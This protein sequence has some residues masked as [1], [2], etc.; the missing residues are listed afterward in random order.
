MYTNELP[1]LLST[2]KLF[3]WCSTWAFI[4]CDTVREKTIKLCKTYNICKKW[5][6]KGKKTINKE[7]CGE[8]EGM[9]EGRGE[10][11]NFSEMSSFL[12]GFCEGMLNF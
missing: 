11:S 9:T 7:E 10:K 5:Q 12:S 1:T 8:E 3:I 4:I 6:R 2:V